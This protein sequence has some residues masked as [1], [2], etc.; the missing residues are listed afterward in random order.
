MSQSYRARAQGTHPLP[1]D[2]GYECIIN[3]LHPDNGS[4]MTEHR[5][6]DLRILLVQMAPWL[7]A[8]MGHD[9]REANLE[10]GAALVRRRL[11]DLGQAEQVVDLVV[12]PE[13]A[14]DGP[15]S[16][17]ADPET[18]IAGSS[19]RILE[20]MS[21][22]AAEVRATVIAPAYSVGP[23]RWH[24]TCFAVGPDGARSEGYEKIHTYPPEQR[25]VARGRRLVTVDVRGFSV[26]LQIC[27]DLAFPEPARCLRLLGAD[28]LVYPTMAPQWLMNRFKV[29]AAARAIENQVFVAVVNAVG[30]HPT[31][32]D[33]LGGG[34]VVAYPDGHRLALGADEDVGLVVL[35]YQDLTRVRAELDILADRVPEAY[36]GLFPGAASAS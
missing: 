11:A 2:N 7:C 35:E 14:F 9:Q 31:S 30:V 28:V 18:T 29:L 24:N 4:M 23:E 34:S 21:G 19:E 33:T 12:F 17:L 16:A 26:G 8:G 20:A 13:F 6:G 10:H 25:V 15:A 1:T 36:A 5:D 22:L 32:G 27:Y 3:F